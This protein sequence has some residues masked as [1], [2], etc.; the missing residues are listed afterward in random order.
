MGIGCFQGSNINDKK[1][2][3]IIINENEIQYDVTIH[4][5]NSRNSY[6]PL[7][8]TFSNQF[9][10][11]I[12]NKRKIHSPGPILRKIISKKKELSFV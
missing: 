3:D 11:E 2:I 5:D 8:S 10:K 9:P 4:N 7:T 6:S 1:Q 12:P